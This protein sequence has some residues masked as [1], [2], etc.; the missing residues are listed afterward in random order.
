MFYNSGDSI[1]SISFLIIVE[2][3]LCC[4]SN[5]QNN[6]FFFSCFIFKIHVAIFFIFVNDAVSFTQTHYN[7][8]LAMSIS[9]ELKHLSDSLEGLFFMTTFIKHSTPQMLQYTEYCLQR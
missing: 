2:S 7:I 3:H 8:G 6:V 5:F 4:C 1:I 9:L